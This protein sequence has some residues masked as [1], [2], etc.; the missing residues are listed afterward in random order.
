MTLLLIKA[1]TTPRHDDSVS[2]RLGQHRGRESLATTGLGWTRACRAACP[3]SVRHSLGPRRSGH[4]RLSPLCWPLASSSGQAAQH[5]SPASLAHSISMILNGD[6]E[7][8]D[9]RSLRASYHA[10]PIQQRP[11]QSQSQAMHEY[12]LCWILCGMGNQPNGAGSQASCKRCADS[13]RYSAAYEHG[14]GRFK[15]L[16]DRPDE[17]SGQHTP[18]AAGAQRHRGTSLV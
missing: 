3:R 17:P 11:L 1:G 7:A 5:D 12:P 6:G 10:T 8:R 4:P 15:A 14:V 9:V 16:R 18:L 2:V 13:S